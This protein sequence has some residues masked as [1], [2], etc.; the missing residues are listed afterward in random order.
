MREEHR[1]EAMETVEVARLRVATRSVQGG[2]DNDITAYAAKAAAALRRDENV[3]IACA[4]SV[5]NVKQTGSLA[6]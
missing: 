6:R 3:S 1:F 2:A 4:S 5:E